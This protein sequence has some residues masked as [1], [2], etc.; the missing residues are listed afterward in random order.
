MV[1][2]VKRSSPAIRLGFKP[3][4]VFV[5]INGK[6]V[7]RVKDMERLLRDEPQPWIIDIRRGKKKLRK[8]IG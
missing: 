6:S 7:K 8:N 3:G 5:Q 1:I 4:D 2:A